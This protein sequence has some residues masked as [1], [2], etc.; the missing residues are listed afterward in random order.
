M[1]GTARSES[2][3]PFSMHRFHVTDDAGFLNLATPAAGFNTMTSPEMNIGHV[4]YQEGIQLYRKKFPGEVTFT[5][6]T[7]TKG[8]VK[9]DTSFYAWVR[10]CA[11]NKAYR[12]NLTIKQYHRDDVSGMIDY[13]SAVPARTYI[14]YNC[15]PIRVKVSTDFDAMTG[16]VAIEDIDIEMEYF[17][18]FNGATEVKAA[19]TAAV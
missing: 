11:E 2:T 7:L 16:E 18:V 8:V 14:C 17:R 13:A 12:T 6:M 3:D 9:N 1:A 10:A 19:G 5:P 4:E 15:L